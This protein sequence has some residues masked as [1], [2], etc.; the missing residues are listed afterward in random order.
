MP[1]GAVVE[2]DWFVDACAEDEKLI[3]GT[4]SVNRESD[5]EPKTGPSLVNGVPSNSR[6]TVHGRPTP[7]I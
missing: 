6:K 2:L 5:G 1:V 3:A 7:R 4:T